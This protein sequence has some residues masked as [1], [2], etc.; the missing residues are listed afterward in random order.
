MAS[1]DIQKP[2]IMEVSK[3]ERAAKLRVFKRAL[4]LLLKE[5]QMDGLTGVHDSVLAEYLVMNLMSIT[6]LMD[7]IYEYEKAND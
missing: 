1:I 2:S 5:H 7:N 3:V 6:K 4:T